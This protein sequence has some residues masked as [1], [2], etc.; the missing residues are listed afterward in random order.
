M[1]NKRLFHYFALYILAQEDIIED[2]INLLKEL[3]GKDCF[4]QPFDDE[5]ILK[6]K[7][8]NYISFT[9]VIRND[10]VHHAR[11]RLVEIINQSLIELNKEIINDEPQTEPE[12]M[13]ILGFEQLA[14][15]KLENWVHELSIN[16]MI[17]KGDTRNHAKLVKY[18]EHLKDIDNINPWMLAYDLLEDQNIFCADAEMNF[19]KLNELFNDSF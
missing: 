13:D 7:F 3:T 4:D 5:N 17:N 14:K 9:R 10:A 16:K 15:Q 6:N 8:Y 2:H 11:K 19:K 12:H 18:Q 1:V